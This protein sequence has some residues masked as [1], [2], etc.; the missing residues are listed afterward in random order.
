[1]QNAVEYPGLGRAGGVVLEDGFYLQV[2]D[3][4][5]CLEVLGTSVSFTDPTKP[6][7]DHRL[8]LGWRKFW[9]LK[10]LLLSPNVS[11]NRR[12]RLFDAT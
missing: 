12:L 7:I 3:E 1:M 6:E 9:A 11:V 10:C 5:E 2:L 8:A 4:S